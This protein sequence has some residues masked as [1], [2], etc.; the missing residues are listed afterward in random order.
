ML[1]KLLTAI[2]VASSILGLL[3]QV[4]G[5]FSLQKEIRDKIF[6][7]IYGFTVGIFVGLLSQTEITFNDTLSFGGILA[8]IVVIGLLIPFIVISI[9]NIGNQESW[10]RLENCIFPCIILLYIFF[11][12]FRFYEL[13]DPY[14]NKDTLD[15]V[16]M[17]STISEIQDKIPQ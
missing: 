4:S 14:S 15:K 10:I 13:N 6:Y 12:V 1:M 5:K 7:S 3:L 8:F 11:I 9:R 2:G 16:R 17:P